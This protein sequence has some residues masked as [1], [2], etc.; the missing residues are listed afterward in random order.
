[1]SGALPEADA[2]PY[3]ERLWPPAWL[4][5][6]AAALPAMLGVAYGA[7]TNALVGGLVGVAAVAV[8]VVGLVD[9]SV[10][11]SVDPSGVTAGRVHLPAAHLGPVHALDA[12][13]SRR[14]RGVDA[15]ARAFL[16]VR[17]W[18]PTGVRLD[19]ADPLDPTPYWYLS[20]RRPE[21]LASAIGAVRVG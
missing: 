8:V 18:V 16:V 3:R 9:A 2:T 17:G 10:V 1:M 15:D 21:E 13:S 5:P 12:E 4:W 7:A 14:L 19:V 11:I 6:A 20:S